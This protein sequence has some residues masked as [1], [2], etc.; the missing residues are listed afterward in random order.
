MS[1]ENVAKFFEVSQTDDPVVRTVGSSR[2]ASVWSEVRFLQF[3]LFV[4]ARIFALVVAL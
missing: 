2:G 3:E 4:A 1:K